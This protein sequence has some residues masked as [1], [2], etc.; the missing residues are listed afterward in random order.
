MKTSLYVFYH[1][2]NFHSKVSHPT[3]HVE[4][5]GGIEE[6]KITTLELNEDNDLYI[7]VEM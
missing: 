1:I 6:E 5:I 7:S 4:L 2:L 3:E